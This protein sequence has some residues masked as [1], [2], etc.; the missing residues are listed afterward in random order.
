MVA[1]T[2]ITNKAMIGLASRTGY[3]V[4]SNHD[5]ARLAKLEK[6]FAPSSAQSADNP[7]LSAA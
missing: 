4:R 3:T 5:D 2:L 7:S 6:I 1:D